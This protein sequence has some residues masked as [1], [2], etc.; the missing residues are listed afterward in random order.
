MA[1]HCGSPSPVISNSK[2]AIIGAGVSG[3]AAAKQLCHHNPII[4]EASEWI[5]GVWKSCA[6]NS[7]KLQSTRKNYEFAEFPWPNRD[8]P[9]F[10][11]KVE[12]LDYLESYA[13]HFD[14]LKFIKFNSKVVELRLAR[15]SE[16]IE[17]GGN[18]GHYWNRPLLGQP[19]WEIAVQTK[20][21]NNLKWYAF[22]FVVI[23]IGL[24]GDMPKVP[25]FPNNK[26]PEIF[27][28]KI[29]H[30]I[31][32]CK[33]NNEAASQL[34][35]GKKVVV[36]GYKKSA[37]D[38]VVECAQANQGAE[39][40]PCTMVV[41]TP[42]WIAPNHRLLRLL[43]S[44]FYTSRFSEFLRERPNQTIFR[45]LICYILSPLRRGISKLMESFIL[46]KLPLK[47]YRLKPD[48]TFEEDITSCQMATVPENFFAEADRG[49]IV[50]KRASDWWFWED[51]IEFDDNTKTKAD[52]VVLATGYNG[53][54]K[55][56]TI[57]PEPCRSMIE[58]PYGIMA[59]YRGTIHPSIPNM[60]FVGYVDS[61]SNVRASELRS[62][63][64]ARLIDEKFKLPSVEIMV[65]Q[66]LTEME[67]MR[68]TIR[69]YKR[70][71]IATFSINHADEIYEEMG[72]E[73]LA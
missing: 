23:C 18:A 6:Y 28:G 46:W 15:P 55:L 64:L 7:T 53:M 32:Y 19:V 47:K 58:Y 17:L 20:D 44:L 33:L 49:N 51:G 52:V 8:D 65:E 56:K 59:L 71:C 29:L 27:K 42:H 36:V 41:R 13:R 2:I 67:F 25:E 60:A 57:L 37:I 72:C 40:Q 50:F 38:L 61:A 1:D 21:S 12:I 48:H 30:T 63:W 22:E 11:S 3:I 16:T 14:V 39:G 73:L 24:F 31:D 4:F 26:G 34:L 45:T 5:G 9:S 10:P 66:T 54:K 43:F 35:E 70:P 62:K 68:R 69:F